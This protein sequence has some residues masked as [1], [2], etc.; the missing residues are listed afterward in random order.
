MPAA[1][2]AMEP[3][4]SCL[5]CA[6]CRFHPEEAPQLVTILRKD[7]AG[8][9]I[10]N[11]INAMAYSKMHGWNFKGALY[12]HAVTRLHAWMSNSRGPAFF[13]NSTKVVIS[14]KAAPTARVRVS[15]GTHW[16]WFSASADGRIRQQL[17]AA[18][19]NDSL[20]QIEAFHGWMEIPLEQLLG[21]KCTWADWA[22][23]C[24]DHN[25]TVIDAYMT[26]P[27]LVALA[28][29]V[30]CTLAAFPQPLYFTRHPSVAIHVRRGDVRRDGKWASRYTD[31]GYYVKAVA[32]IRHHWPAADIHAFSALEASGMSRQDDNKTFS[33]LTTMGVA[34]HFDGS[35]KTDWA[36]FIQADIVV[37]A[38]SS[39][40]HAAA[41]ARRRGCVVYQPFWAGKLS[42]WTTLDVLNETLPACA[43]YQL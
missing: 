23:R 24:A 2:H 40:S 35:A 9:G 29:D 18:R 42:S 30:A 27:F 37:L 41:L 33:Q 25:G 10:D 21:Q 4:S 28:D 17:N 6:A 38:K 34:L 26:R 20:V 32:I 7:G 13:F 11:L 39:F 5:G 16:D 19:Q 12:T 22:T 15:L 43:A 36:H 31:V 8:A 14:G 1:T 3:S